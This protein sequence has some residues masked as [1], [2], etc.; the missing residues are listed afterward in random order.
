MPR[1][2]WVLGGVGVILVQA[3]LGEKSN[4]H[5][6]NV[7]VTIYILSKALWLVHVYCC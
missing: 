5:L 1:E 2:G 7:N 4:V 6:G 3:Q